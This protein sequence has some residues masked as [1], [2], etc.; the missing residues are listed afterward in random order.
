MDM[1]WIWYGFGMNLVWIWVQRKRALGERAS[2]KNG[3]WF[4]KAKAK[5]RAAERFIS[6][7]LGKKSVWMKLARLITDWFR[8]GTRQTQTGAGGSSQANDKAGN[9]RSCSPMG[10][11]C[12]SSKQ[13]T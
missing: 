5:W 3:S 4:E 8:D 2:A 1:V 6:Y 9:Y 12:S 11:A 13:P 7:V 10:K